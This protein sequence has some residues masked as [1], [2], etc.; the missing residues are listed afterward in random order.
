M[1]K[2]YRICLGAGDNMYHNECIAGG[3]VGAR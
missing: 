1:K 3:F 2:Y